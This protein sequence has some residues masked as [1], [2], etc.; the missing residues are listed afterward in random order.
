MGKREKEDK[1]REGDSHRKRGENQRDWGDRETD[2]KTH[3]WGER[4]LSSC[5]LPCAPATSWAS[6]SSLGDVGPDFGVA[7][8]APLSFRVCLRTWVRLW[9]RKGPLRASQRRTSCGSTLHPTWPWNPGRGQNWCLLS[10]CRRMGWPSTPPRP[11]PLESGG[12]CIHGRTPQRGARP[13]A[14]SEA[15]V[16]LG[17]GTREVKRDQVPKPQRSKHMFLRGT[18]RSALSSASAQ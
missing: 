11:L 12:Q 8:A 1:P 9:P 3:R 13:G 2:L 6:A 7:S 14:S 4:P 17:S 18:L 16:C 15:P 10:L 5:G